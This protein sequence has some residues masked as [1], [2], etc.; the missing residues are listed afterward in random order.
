MEHLS[1]EAKTNTKACGLYKL[2]GDTQVIAFA[3]FIQMVS[4][5]RLVNT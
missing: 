4:L 5:K 2:L 1:V 3:K